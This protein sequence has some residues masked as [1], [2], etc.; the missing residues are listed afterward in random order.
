MFDDTGG[1]RMAVQVTSLAY[2]SPNKMAVCRS[3]H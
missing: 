1:N 3:S 2:P